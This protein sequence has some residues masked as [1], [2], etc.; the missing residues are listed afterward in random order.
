MANQSFLLTYSQEEDLQYSHYHP[1]YQKTAIIPITMERFSGLQCT[2]NLDYVWKD[3]AYPIPHFFEGGYKKTSENA[4]D[5]L[6]SFS[7]QCEYER[8]ALSSVVRALMKQLTITFASLR[9]NE[10]PYT[11]ASMI[12]RKNTLYVGE[13]VDYDTT[14]SEELIQQCQFRRLV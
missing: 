9:K 6:F 10:P 8:E 13:S 3:N 14:F 2:G 4:S 12:Y 7:F 5:W 1:I 11:A